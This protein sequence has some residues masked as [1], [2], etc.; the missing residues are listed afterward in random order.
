VT[1][2]K[3]Y[4]LLICASV[5]L[6]VQA[7]AQT[8]DR[9]ELLFLDVGQ[10]DAILIRSQEGNVALVDAGPDGGVVDKLRQHGVSFINIAVAS[11]AHADHIGGMQAV[12]E[13]LPV[14]YYTDNGMPHTTATYDNLMQ[15]IEVRNTRYFE[16]TKRRIN[17]GSVAL[18]FIPPP[19]DGDQNNNS[20]G[21]LVEYGRFKAML[22]GD[23]EAGELRHFLDEG[24]SQL[25]V[26]KAP[27]HGSRDGL[28][29]AWLNITQPQ[30]V[31]VSCGRG[32]PYGH[33]SRWALRYYENVA[34]HV[35]RTDIDGDV[36]VFG[37]RDGTYRVRTG[38]QSPAGERPE[39]KK[40]TN[41]N[42]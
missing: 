3:A 23:S 38:S 19:G 40:N 4:A 2:I 11:H 42:T 35:Y 30:V 24:V 5:L 25:T 27:H 1:S 29:P 22:T 36:L 13:S 14:E 37:A 26:L 6:V 18:T 8:P 17:L 33:P 41:G 15:A 34:E 12:V 28:T 21:V 7:A 31:V 9:V 32:N 16:A 39:Y 20:L 10:G